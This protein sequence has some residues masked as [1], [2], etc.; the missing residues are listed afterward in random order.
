[1]P[2]MMSQKKSNQR[3][4]RRRLASFGNQAEHSKQKKKNDQGIW[5]KA[6]LHAAVLSTGPFA[7]SFPELRVDR[8]AFGQLPI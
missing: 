6:N 1:M 8:F 4:W 3:T 7:F 5:V 2:Q